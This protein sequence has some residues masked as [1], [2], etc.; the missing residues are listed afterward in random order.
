MKAW[1]ITSTQY[2]KKCLEGIL[3]SLVAP[4]KSWLICS[5]EWWGCEM[6]SSQVVIV[7]TSLTL[8]ICQPGKKFTGEPM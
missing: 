3:K 2:S 6:T 8:E 7:K 4:F 1:V 5:T